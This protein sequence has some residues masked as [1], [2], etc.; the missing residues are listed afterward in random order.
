M[1]DLLKLTEQFARVNDRENEFAYFQTNLA[2]SGSMVYLNVVF[3]PAP[4]QLLK[5]T[6]A[7][8]DLPHPY[9]EFL[10]KQN[11]AIVFSGALN[12]YGVVSP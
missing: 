1:I 12:S 2:S 8:L 7:A 5:A 6:K 9:V 10:S 3:K 11:G 4:T